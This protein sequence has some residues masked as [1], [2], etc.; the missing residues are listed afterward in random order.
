MKTRWGKVGGSSLSS[1]SVLVQ[2]FCYGTRWWDPHTMLRACL[3]LSKKH[4]LIYRKHHH[5]MWLQQAVLRAADHSYLFV[6]TDEEPFSAQF[7][8]GDAGECH[9]VH[10]LTNCFRRIMKITWLGWCFLVKCER[11]QNWYNQKFQGFATKSLTFYL[12]MLVG[13]DY[14]NPLFLLLSLFGWFLIFSSHMGGRYNMI[15]SML[16]TTHLILE[17]KLSNIMPV[18]LGWEIPWV[19]H[20]SQYPY[21]HNPFHLIL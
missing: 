20:L 18:L 1:V 12:A 11:K 21:K 19:L 10:F 14:G 8:I 3:K 2:T 4:F 6:S 9:V 17:A 15:L 7:M 5:F 13:R 16:N